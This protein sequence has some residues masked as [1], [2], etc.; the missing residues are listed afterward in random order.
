ERGSTEHGNANVAVHRFIA[1][2]GA[3]GLFL[4]SFAVPISVSAEVRSIMFP[5]G[6]PS[7]FRDDF[8]E[9]RGT[10]GTRE[11][12]GIDIIADKMTPVVSAVDGEVSY[13]VTPEASWGYSISIRDADGY[14]YRYLHLNNDTPGTD[15]GNG[16]E[17]NAY[18]PGIRRGVRVVKG[19][20]IGWVGDSGNAENTVSHLHFEIRGLS[21]TVINPYESLRS[22]SSGDM[23]VFTQDISISKLVIAIPKD[24]ILI[25]YANDPAIFLLS[26]NIKYRILNT[27]TL[28]ALGK[29]A[30]DARVIPDNEQ[31]PTGSSISIASTIATDHAS[32]GAEG[33][34]LI[35]LSLE[36]SEG[37][38]GPAVVELQTTLKVLGY[39][40]SAVTDYFGPITK[41]AV[42]KFQIAKGLDPIGVVGPQTRVA[43]SLTYIPFASQAIGTALVPAAGLFIE[44]HEGMSG[45]AVRQLQTALKNLGLFTYAVTGYFG[46]IT[47]VA[48]IKFQIAKGLD[49]VG[50]VGPKTRTAL[51][52]TGTSIAVVP[53]P[54]VGL[55][56]VQSGMMFRLYDSAVTVIGSVNPN[57][58]ATTDWFEYGETQ[59][60]GTRT[61][62]RAIGAGSVSTSTAFY[63][64]GLYPNTTYYI[65]LNAENKF[66]VA[67]NTTYNFEASDGQN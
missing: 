53:I 65:R 19:Q 2:A 20:L 1:S 23:A 8:N 43:L 45:E 48:V 57:G 21:R 61:A 4:T 41:D 10:D 16:G 37:S 56:I 35:D 32:T 15:D 60:L 51:G 63:V 3:I 31:Y 7:V 66:G 47:K 25:K 42:I 64:T 59:A 5:V 13:A 29:S 54:Q 9:P 6:G 50:V 22:V 33:A 36:L 58:S 44:L 34:G 38:R 18:A 24:Y 40:T 17:T 27:G 11:H 30:S 49:P 12:L 67:K 55:P 52:L 62:S 46:P 26:K 14:S 39:F 28:N